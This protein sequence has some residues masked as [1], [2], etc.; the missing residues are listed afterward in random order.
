MYMQCDL[1]CIALGC[2]VFH[3]VR[4]Q[5]CWAQIHS[6]KSALISHFLGTPVNN[7]SCFLS[8]VCSVQF[9]RHQPVGAPAPSL[10]CH[11][12][13]QFPH[14]SCLT[15]QPASSHLA[16]SG[17]SV[18]S[19]FNQSYPLETSLPCSSAQIWFYWLDHFRTGP[20]MS[21]DLTESHGKKVIVTWR[22]HHA[23]SS[24]PPC[25]IRLPNFFVSNTGKM[26]KCVKCEKCVKHVHLTLPPLP[27]W[28]QSMQCKQ[29]ASSKI[30]PF[31]AVV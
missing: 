1:S 3:F 10:L 7:I 28:D 23:A 26:C 15:P 31:P 17:Q 12:G 27:L 14:V 19:H 11:N 24:S 18:I 2:D 25:A 16:L 4:G 13:D 9:E 29:N 21:L 22:P 6:G 30:A 5:G 8:R 20:N